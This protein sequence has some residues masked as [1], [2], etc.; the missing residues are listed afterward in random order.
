[1]EVEDVHLYISNDILNKTKC[2]RKQPGL[3][4]INQ[5]CSIHINADCLASLKSTV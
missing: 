1:M 4:K 5:F 3:F 2:S